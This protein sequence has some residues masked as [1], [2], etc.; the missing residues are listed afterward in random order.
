MS[1]KAQPEPEKK[2][3]HETKI[4]SVAVPDIN[5]FTPGH[6]EGDTD[7]DGNGPSVYVSADVKRKGSQL[8]LAV[9][10]IFQETKSDWTTFEGH[11]EETFYDVS[12]QHPGWRILSIQ[13]NFHQVYQSVLAGYGP[14]TISSFG[15]SDFVNNMVLVGDTDGGPFGADDK[16][17]VVK[18]GFNKIELKLIK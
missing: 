3:H 13:G 6:T 18:L 10:A 5:N 16:P 14:Q 4:I 1:T 12:I 8:V 11:F 2:R 7:F 17:R 9:Y 15:T